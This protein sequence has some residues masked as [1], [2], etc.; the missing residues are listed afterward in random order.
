MV[1]SHVSGVIFTANPVNGTDEIVIESTWG[2]GEAIVSGMVTPDVYV[3]NREGN[4]I[5]ENIKTKEK[6]YF[7]IDG[8][9]KLVSI[10]EDKRKKSSFKAK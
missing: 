8:K 2:L 7:L 1:D 9:N 3:L 6:G 4:I 10:D 5:Q